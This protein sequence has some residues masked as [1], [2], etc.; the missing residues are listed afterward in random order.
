VERH[1]ASVVGEVGLRAL[2]SR[3]DH[4]VAVGEIPDDHR[5]AHERGDAAAV[6]RDQR[7]VAGADALTRHHAAGGHHTAI[8]VEIVVVAL[9]REDQI[10]A[11]ALRPAEVVAEIGGCDVARERARIRVADGDSAATA[12]LAEIDHALAVHREIRVDAALGEQRLL[13]AQI[14]PSPALSG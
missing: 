7:P 6:L 13:R 1:V 8:A 10:L 14:T 4:V 5:P 3:I 11:V 12:G 2:Q 9:D